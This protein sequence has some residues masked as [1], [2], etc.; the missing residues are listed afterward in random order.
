MTLALRPAT[1]DDARRVF[2]WR[3]EPAARAASRN[4]GELD[5]AAH[6]A[7]FPDALRTRRMLI[8]ELEG[9]PVGMVR[10]DPAGDGA[11]VSIALAPE[12]RG[13]GLGRQLLD[14]ALAGEDGPLLAEVREDN[15][16]SLRI[17]RDCGFVEVGR[18]G[19]FLQL[20]RG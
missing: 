14:A 3:N 19:R 4:T 17:F 1:P 16:A 12:R 5:W 6:K 8:A 15:A 18:D 2:D 9:E 10:L 20:R 11:V 7:W 13:Q